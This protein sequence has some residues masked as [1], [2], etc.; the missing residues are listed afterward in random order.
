MKI[1]LQTP[2]AGPK[3]PHHTA[4]RTAFFSLSFLAVCGILVLPIRSIHGLTP[5]ADAGVFQYIGWAMTKG[6][7]PYKDIFDHKGP[8]LYY[9]NALGYLITPHSSFGLGI[10]EFLCFAA[11]LLL[12][13]W[14]LLQSL[15]ALAAVVGLFVMLVFLSVHLD[16]GNFTENWALLPIALSWVTVSSWNRHSPHAK[17][18]LVLGTTSAVT[19]WLRPNLAALPMLL[20]LFGG[21]LL[22]RSRRLHQFGVALAS[23]LFTFFLITA[24]FLMPIRAAGAWPAFVNDFFAYNA[25]YTQG[26]AAGERVH[27]LIELGRTELRIIPMWLPCLGLIIGYIIALLSPSNLK[28]LFKQYWP[29]SFVFLSAPLEL[30]AALASGRTYPHYL[31]PLAPT[32]ALLSGSLVQFFLYLSRRSKVALAITALL[33]LAVAAQGVR[34]IRL[35]QQLMFAQNFG[36]TSELKALVQKYTTPDDKILVYAGSFA[37]GFNLEEERLSPTQFAYQLPLIHDALPNAQAER[38]AFLA[39]LE[40][41]PPKLILNPLLVPSIGKL[42]AENA[43][44]S[45]CEDVVLETGYH[46]QFLIDAIAGFI[47]TNY[48]F[49]PQASSKDVRVF[50]RRDLAEASSLQVQSH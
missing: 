24:A 19:F 41:N 40:V 15:D 16:G 30:A 31:L 20:A 27:L 21:I 9:I 14:L 36:R 26:M 34:R 32:V 10:L 22:I 7:L 8:P 42:C 2:L 12:L 4:T 50:L 35:Y 49:L 28:T 17:Q 5:N 25:R 6:L 23:Y 33:L 45:P 11:T 29:L 43:P 47:Q 37:P 3:S 39:S 38:E 13:A 18:Y 48:R 46:C 1:Q 44:C